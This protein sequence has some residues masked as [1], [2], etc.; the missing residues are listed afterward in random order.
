MLVDLCIIVFCVE[1]DAYLVILR[2]KDTSWTTV[3]DV[4][5]EETKRESFLKIN[6]E[7]TSL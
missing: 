1:S 2:A 3:I 4:H 7:I 5:R 6:E